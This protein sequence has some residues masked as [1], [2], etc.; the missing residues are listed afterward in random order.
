MSEPYEDP[1]HEDPIRVCRGM[2]SLFLIW[3]VILGAVGVL[4]WVLLVH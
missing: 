1:T 2:C 3:A 4:V